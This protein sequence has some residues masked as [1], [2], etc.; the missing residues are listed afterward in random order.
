[1]RSRE[2][3]DKRSPDSYRICTLCGKGTE[4]AGLLQTK[5]VFMCA[6]IWYAPLP[7]LKTAN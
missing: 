6:T 7:E 4:G 2:R 5:R 3:V 1:M